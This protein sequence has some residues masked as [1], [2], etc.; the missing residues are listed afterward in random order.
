MKPQPNAL[1]LAFL[2]HM[3]I[4]AQS[5]VRIK[6]NSSTTTIKSRGVHPSKHLAMRTYLESVDMDAILNSTDSCEGKTSLLDQII[7]TGLDLRS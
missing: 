6:S 2:D 7:R 4:E 3:S 5:K 1:H